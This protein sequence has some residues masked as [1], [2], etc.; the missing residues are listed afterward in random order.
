MDDVRAA[1]SNDEDGFLGTAP[2][3]LRDAALASLHQA[4]EDVYLL[5]NRSLSRINARSTTGYCSQAEYIRELAAR[6]NAIAGYAVG[7]GLVSSEDA[8]DAVLQFQSR[9]GE[10]LSTIGRPPRNDRP[11]HMPGRRT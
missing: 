11:G 2:A 3:Q 4:Y 9:H 8:R 5:G 7:L 10:F 6:A 1:M